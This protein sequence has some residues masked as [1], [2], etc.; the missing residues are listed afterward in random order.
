MFA[1]FKERHPWAVVV[2][3]I[4]CGPFIGGLYLGRGKLAI[5][6]LLV[7]AVIYLATYFIVMSFEIHDNTDIARYF[8]FMVIKAPIAVHFYLIAKSKLIDDHV[9]WFS[10]WYVILLI[11]YALPILLAYFMKSYF[12]EAY[13][14]ASHSMAP[15]IMTGDQFMA[16]KTAYGY[17]KFT[18]GFGAF[19]ESGR[20]FGSIPEPGDI[21]VFKLPSD[22]KTE[23][24]KRVVGLPGDIVQLRDGQLFLNDIAT[25]TDQVEETISIPKT[26]IA[27][28]NFSTY[29][30]T[31]PNGSNFLILDQEFEWQ[32]DNTEKYLVPEGHI[33]VLGDNRDN[34]N[35]S[36][37]PRVGFVP[38]ENVMGKVV[39]IYWR[40][41]GNKL[42]F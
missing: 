10:K 27:T 6:Y 36:R 29:K 28:G 7:E 9:A 39:W 20:V 12:I 32:S 1:A 40:E 8:V 37:F 14:A 23:F 24:V 35:D 31:L 16:S 21:I 18:F 11:A 34:S 38:I 17:S 5:L 15:T 19:I 30:E 13:S 26:G 4:F 42:E 2:I 22:N 25:I 41:R 3:T 33:F